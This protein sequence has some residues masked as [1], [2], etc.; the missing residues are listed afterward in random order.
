MKPWVPGSKPETGRRD[1]PGSPVVKN[2]PFR[3]GDMG[4]IPGGD[5]LLFHNKDPAQPTAP[6]P[7][8]NKNKTFKNLNNKNEKNQEA[9][10]LSVPQT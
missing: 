9:P 3:A 10:V 1:F 5:P 7:T 2:L 8:P 6:P 4:W